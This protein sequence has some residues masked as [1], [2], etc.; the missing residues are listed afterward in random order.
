MNLFPARTPAAAAWA[1]R[2][3]PLGFGSAA[4]GNLY[5]AVSD[6]QSDET[7]AAARGAG[8]RYIDTAPHYGLGLSEERLGRVLPTWPRAEV[9]VSSKVGRLLAET[10]DDG[11]AARDDGDGFQVPRSRRRVV[12]ISEAGF[13]AS[14]RASCDRLG[15][16]RL[17]I[18]FLHDPEELVPSGDWLEALT[19]LAELRAE[20]L[21]DAIGV[22]SKDPA[23]LQA[24]VEHTDL[25]LVM[26]AGRFTLLDTSGGQ[27]LDRCAQRGTAAVAVGVYNSGILATE[28]PRAD[29][30][31]DYTQAQPAVLERAR[32]IAAVCRR[33]GVSLPEAAVQFPFT[34][35]AVANVTLGLRSPQE[36]TAAVHRCGVDMPQA[37]W[38]DLDHAGLVSARPG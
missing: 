25:D 29:A 35:P 30:T 26:M 21:I 33:H 12:D 38:T 9:I 8:L 6:E 11:A 5:R 32:H 3:G 18:A 31:F 28:F 15:L 23:T 17:D 34:H 22:G 4:L 10:D 13:R 2:L 19:T 14:V 20:G 24:A 7:L 16:D 37:L 1:A 36:V 27:L